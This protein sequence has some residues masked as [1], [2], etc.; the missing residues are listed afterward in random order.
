[1]KRISLPAKKQTKNFTVVSQSEIERS[2]EKMH[3]KIK[4]QNSS[5]EK[6]TYG[7]MNT[8]SEKY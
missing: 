4:Q 3:I 8:L 6:T 2:T 5:K 7:R 1:M